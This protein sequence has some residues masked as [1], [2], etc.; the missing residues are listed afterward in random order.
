[1]EQ[2]VHQDTINEK[3]Y[4]TYL[5]D[6]VCSSGSND[7]NIE[8]RYNQGVSS[9]GQIMTILNQVSLGHYHVEMGLSMRD[10]I[11]ISKLVFNSEVWYNVTDKQITEL[12]H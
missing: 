1:M 9:V 11:L 3:S 8:H 10:T 4:E 7:R 2:K 5:G 6:I 12:E